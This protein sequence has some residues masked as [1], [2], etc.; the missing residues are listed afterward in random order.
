[1][2][3]QRENW[4]D[5]KDTHVHHSKK[6]RKGWSVLGVD[7]I[8]A[9]DA[10]N[11]TDISFATLI[12][13]T[14]RDTRIFDYESYLSGCEIAGVEPV[15][16]ES[17]SRRH[18]FGWNE[19]RWIRSNFRIWKEDSPTIDEISRKFKIPKTKVYSI[20][21]CEIWKEPSKNTRII[22]YSG[23]IIDSVFNR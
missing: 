12:K 5:S 20:I 17:I 21:L 10:I 22:K 18:S 23:K 11:K 2:G 14:C 16:K 3:S 7:Y 1:M 13:Y 9:R 4:I 19:V 15:T 8:T 6:L